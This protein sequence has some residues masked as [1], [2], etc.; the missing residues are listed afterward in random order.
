MCIFDIIRYV[1]VIFF[2]FVLLTK[3]THAFK[4]GIEICNIA[5]EELS[6]M[7]DCI[8]TGK[9]ESLIVADVLD[10]STKFAIV[11]I[12]RIIKLDEKYFKNVST[13]SKVS[14]KLS[15]TQ[16]FDDSYKVVYRFQNCSEEH[17]FSDVKIR[18]VKVFVVRLPDK[19]YVNVEHFDRNRV[20]FPNELLGVSLPLNL[21]ILD[22]FSAVAEGKL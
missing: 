11:G 6:N 4:S 2:G 17:V 13:G 15:A 9:V 5:L 21:Q 19:S 8:F 22:E 20:Y 14:V 3:H 1:M 7:A 16:F 18:D 10:H 12:K